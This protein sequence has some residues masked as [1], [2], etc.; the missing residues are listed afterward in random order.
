MARRG[1]V[2]IASPLTRQRRF[3][4]A[5]VQ[6]EPAMRINALQQI[7]EF[8]WFGQIALRAAAQ[9]LLHDGIEGK[10]DTADEEDGGEPVD[11]ALHAASMARRGYY[12]KFSH[13]GV[14]SPYTL[15]Y[16]SL[17]SC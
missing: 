3:A 16:W 11:E 1:S 15:L 8:E 10:I 5:V 9:G 4:Q 13:N 17:D 12:R 6:R 2:A 7:G 14:T